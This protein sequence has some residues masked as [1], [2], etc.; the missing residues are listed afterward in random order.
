MLV[1]GRTFT[2]EPSRDVTSPAARGGSF[3]GGKGPLHE[4]S[5]SPATTAE[6]HPSVGWNPSPESF[7]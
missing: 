6:R 5:I 4:G 7:V 2:P 3:L 1:A